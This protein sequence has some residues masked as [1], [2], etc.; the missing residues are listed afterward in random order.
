MAPMAATLVNDAAVENVIAHIQTFQWLTPTRL[1]RFEVLC[2]EL[3]GIAHFA[4]RGAVIV[5]TQEDFDSWLDAQPTYAE[6]NAKP[7][8]NATVGAAQY[9]VCAACHG[10]QGEG[11]AALN[12]PKVHVARARTTRMV[13]KWRR[14]PRHWSMM[15]R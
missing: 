12:A 5:D 13:S 4:M 9:A 11:L 10:Q 8:G 2:E 7:A 14:W 3:C 6:L 1:G 15:R